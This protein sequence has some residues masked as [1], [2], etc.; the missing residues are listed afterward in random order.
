MRKSGV[1]IETNSLTVVSLGR[2][3]SLVIRGEYEHSVRYFAWNI[4]LKKCGL[5]K[6]LTLL[7]KDE[8][9]T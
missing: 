8:E 7:I 2:S 9:K 4:W 6:L 5:L 1:N 3:T